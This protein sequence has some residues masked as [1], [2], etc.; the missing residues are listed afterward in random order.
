M[1]ELKH[2]SKHKPPML[3]CRSI[4]RSAQTGTMR[5]CCTSQQMLQQQPTQNTQAHTPTP[6][7]TRACIQQADKQGTEPEPD[8]VKSNFT[9]PP[10]R[11]PTGFSWAALK[12]TILAAVPRWSRSCRQSDH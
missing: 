9:L 6:A 11:N 3:L 5:S 10:S 8:R 4:C 1:P 12:E 7:R 2:Y